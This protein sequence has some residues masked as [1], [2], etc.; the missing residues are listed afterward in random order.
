MLLSLP[1]R[2]MILTIRKSSPVCKPSSPWSDGPSDSCCEYPWLEEDHLRTSLHLLARLTTLSAALTST[3]GLLYLYFAHAY[4]F[5][6]DYVNA[7]HV[8]DFI[9]VAVVFV[10][11]AGYG[12]V[13]GFILWV[14]Y[15]L[16]MFG[17]SR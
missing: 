4:P 12:L 15:R 9:D 7:S 2:Y 13:A 5:A 14:V 1:K 11:L 3:L 6:S 16:A 17:M 10:S 8:P